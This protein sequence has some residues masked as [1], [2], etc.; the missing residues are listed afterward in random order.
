MMSLVT[1]QDIKYCYLPLLFGTIAL[2]LSFLELLESILLLCRSYGLVKIC[3]ANSQT[4]PAQNRMTMNSKREKC[5][6]LPEH[7]LPGF[8]LSPDPLGQRPSLHILVPDQ[9][10]LLALH[11]PLE[12]VQ[13][14]LVVNQHLVSLQEKHVL[15]LSL[16][17]LM[18]LMELSL[19]HFP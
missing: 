1:K 5:N 4:F 6:C 10:L 19:L 17:K 18:S 11:H 2:L 3:H 13:L 7:H 15:E 12:V 16:G 9:L 14:L 8:H